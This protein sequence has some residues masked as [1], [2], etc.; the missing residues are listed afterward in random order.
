MVITY[1]SWN[2]SKEKYTRADALE[3]SL[4][5]PDITY[6]N[7]PD[8]IRTSL[9]IGIRTSGHWIF[10]GHGYYDVTEVGFGKINHE[11][12]FE[13][14]T[15]VVNAI[16]KRM[17]YELSDFRDDEFV[18]EFELALDDVKVT[19]ENSEDAINDFL[20]YFL[21]IKSEFRG[22]DSFD[23][24]RLELYKTKDDLYFSML[25]SEITVIEIREHKDRKDFYK[26]YNINGEFESDFNAKAFQW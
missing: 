1:T 13:L 26:T 25:F 9:S 22:E 15:D 17:K 10:R 21:V 3:V 8:T 4:F 24:L 16:V 2:W 7:G 14:M 18:R 12:L 11:T 6:I 19:E 20:R 23:G 5:H